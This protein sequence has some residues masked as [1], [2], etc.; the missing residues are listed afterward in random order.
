VRA[1]TCVA[2]VTKHHA[3]TRA[4]AKDLP[5]RVRDQVIDGTVLQLEDADGKAPPSIS[6]GLKGHDVERQVLRP[7]YREQVGSVSARGSVPAHLREG[8]N[9]DARQRL[10]PMLELPALCSLAK[11]C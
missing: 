7:R 5:Q 11:C 1:F 3:E 2:A 9:D 10:G 6:G 8:A 4:N